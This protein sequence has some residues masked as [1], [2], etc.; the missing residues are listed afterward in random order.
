MG[1][2]VLDALSWISRIRGHIPHDDDFGA[3]RS[4]PPFADGTG[5][6]MFVLGVFVVTVAFLSL[7]LWAAVWLA[8]HSL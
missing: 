5:R 4:E 2:Y 3:S 1:L 8:I 6:L 7:A